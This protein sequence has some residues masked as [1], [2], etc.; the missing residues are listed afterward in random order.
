V[1]Q[2]RLIRP[3]RGFTF[4]P[5]ARALLIVGS[6]LIGAFTH[7]IWDGFTHEYGWAVN[8][9][10]FL[11]RPVIEFGSGT[12]PLFKVFQHSSTAIGGGL[13][14]LCVIRWFSRAPC[15]EVSENFRRPP[16]YKLSWGVALLIGATILGCLSS[17]WKV[18]QSGNQSGL[19]TW[20]ACFVVG[21]LSGLFVELLLFGIYSARIDSQINE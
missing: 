7:I 11:S 14:L 5:V 15:E 21:A 1:L 6:L 4:W 12:I 9:L 10:P 8:R 16:E 2:A 13:L 18:A 3:A 19:K 17:W 20:L